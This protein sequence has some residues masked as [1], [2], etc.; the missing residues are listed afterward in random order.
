MYEIDLDTIKF[1]TGISLPDIQNTLSILYPKVKYDYEKEIV[2]VVNF[3]RHQFMRTENTS[4]KIITGIKNNLV[5]NNGHFFIGEFLEEYQSLSI[6]YEYPI[7]RVSEG[8]QYPPGGGGGEGKGKKD[9]KVKEFIPPSEKEVIEYFIKNGYLISSA[10]KAFKF[11]AEAEPPWTDTR[12]NKIR[13]WKQKMIGV[14]FKEE[15]K[16]HSPAAQKPK[17]TTEIKNELDRDK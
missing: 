11:Y 5:Q 7:D 13:G 16:D 17:S 8:Y 1:Y 3:V 6:S 9:N 14:W 12:G 4:P 2:W 10:K 15:N